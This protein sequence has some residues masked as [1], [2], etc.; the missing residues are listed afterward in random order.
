M[1][2]PPYTQPGL[3]DPIDPAGVDTP[4]PIL[5]A[6]GKRIQ[7]QLDAT[8]RLMQNG[9]WWTIAELAKYTGASEAGQSA[10]IRDLRKHPYRYRVER[11]R[12]ALGSAVYEYRLLA[13]AP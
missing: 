5:P 13:P 1:S 6:D 3:F 7:T 8:R 11:R 4:C 9:L 10:R 12:I 2:A